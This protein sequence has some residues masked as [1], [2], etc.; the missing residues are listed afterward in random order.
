MAESFLQEGQPL[1][2]EESIPFPKRV[3]DTDPLHDLKVARGYSI[4]IGL[5][6]AKAGQIRENNC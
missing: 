3:F 4:S 2:P 6:T 5:I 1:A